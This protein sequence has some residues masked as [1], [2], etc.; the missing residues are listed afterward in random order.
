[1]IVE[2]LPSGSKPWEIN[3]QEIAAREYAKCAIAKSRGETDM[4]A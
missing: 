2:V 4:A 1:M 3:A